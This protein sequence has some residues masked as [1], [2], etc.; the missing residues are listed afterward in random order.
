MLILRTESGQRPGDTVEAKEGGAIKVHIEAISAHPLTAVEIVVNGKVV[1]SFD[2]EDAKLVTGTRELRIVEGSWIAARCTARDA[3]L[4]DDELAAYKDTSD[5]KAFRV[6]PSRLR[7]AHTSPIYVAVGRE[8]AAVTKSIVEGFQMLERF[9]VFAQETADAPYERDTKD[10]IQVA[11]TRLMELAANRPSKDVVRYTIHRS[12]S[13][14][15]ID[16]QLDEKVWK[17]AAA[18]GDFKF[19]WWTEGK[20]EQTS[21][22]LLWDDEN[23]YVAFRCEDAHVWAEHTERD[24]PVYRDDCVEVFTAPN[25]DQPFN[26]FNIEMNV[27]EAFLDQHHPNGPGNHETPD[28]NAQGVKIA[29]KVDGTLNNDA[30][31][32]RGWR[33]EAAIP[34]ANFK[35]AAQHTPPNDG[36]VWH[37]NLNRLGGKT[38][39]QHSQWS[40]S[41][42]ERPAF[43]T[44]QYFGRVVFSRRYPDSRRER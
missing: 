21:A 29:T 18:V 5:N 36:D 12:G 4:T 31:A 27:R 10:A 17:S 8:S 2:I 33:L 43:H 37:L 40:S 26:Y 7:F 44:P 23:L 25:P 15:K 35:V 14:I 24:S 42:T 39:P 1:A 20:K 3:L 19:P 16:G 38:N 13:E 11:R 41:K 32:D 9:E 22:K 34:F 30:D 28:W 6:A